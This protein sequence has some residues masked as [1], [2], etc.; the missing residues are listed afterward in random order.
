[1][2]VIKLKGGATITPE[3]WKGVT[4]DKFVKIN[5]S[6]V[7]QFPEHERIKI[8]KECYKDISKKKSDK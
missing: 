8:L 1:M 6:L 3:A 7:K 4:E 2:D 5:K